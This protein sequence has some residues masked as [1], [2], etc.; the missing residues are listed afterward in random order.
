MP[1]QLSSGPLGRNPKGEFN[2]H[3]KIMILTFL[4]FCTSAFSQ[5]H[6]PLQIGNQW[7]YGELEL[8][9]Q[10]TYLYSLLIVGDTTMP[11]GKTYAVEKSIYGK[12]FLREQDSL[13]LQYLSGKDTAIY[14]YSYQ[15]GDTALF[16]Q[17]GPYITTVIVYVGEG[18]LFGRTLKGWSYFTTTNTSSDGGS[19]ITI[20]DSIGRTYTFI[21]GGYS[22][23]LMGALIDGK[24]Y[25]TVLGVPLQANTKP[26]EF[27]LFQ[28]FPNP[29][30]P[31]TTIQFSVPVRAEIELVLYST[32]GKKVAVIFHG[33]ED[34]GVHTARI[35][36]SELASGVYFVE[37]LTK[38]VSISKSIVLLK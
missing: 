25:G 38:N 5:G 3:L 27:K 2:M 16:I 18:Q 10:F 24:K 22:E 26:S 12:R 11:N 28:N 7:D 15:N 17:N 30:N 32:L 36:G 14:N 6:Y 31:I 23:Y 8:A 13:L 9:G 19:R 34:P 35:D 4:A 1:P 37:L 29:F 33:I 21:D 20:T